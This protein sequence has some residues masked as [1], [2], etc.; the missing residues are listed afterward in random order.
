MSFV[1]FVSPSAAASLAGQPL[2]LQSAAWGLDLSTLGDRPAAHPQ[3]AFLC[4]RRVADAPALGCAI[5]AAVAAG[6]YPDIPTAAKTMVQ[7][8][9]GG[10]GWVCK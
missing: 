2:A 10:L 5:L 4:A 1:T 6:L 8:G 3:V 7:V 9:S